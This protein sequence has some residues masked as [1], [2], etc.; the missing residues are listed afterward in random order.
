MTPDN[1]VSRWAAL[2]V[3]AAAASEGAG[4]HSLYGPGMQLAAAASGRGPVG[5]REL[6]YFMPGVNQADLATAGLRDVVLTRTWEQTLEA[7]R[8]RHGS[9]ARVAVFPCGTIQLATA[10]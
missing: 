3:L 10:S 7:L 2:V 9:R 1:R 6:I 8:A 5:A 4:F